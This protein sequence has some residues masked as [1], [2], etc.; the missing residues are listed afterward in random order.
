MLWKKQKPEDVNA[1]LASIA[2]YFVES[3]LTATGQHPIQILWQRSDAAATNQ[4]ALLGDALFQMGSV[5]HL[6]VSRRVEEIKTQNPNN[7]AGKVFELLGLNIFAGDGQTVRPTP[8]GTPGFDGTV[9]F[10]SGLSLKLSLKSHA[11]WHE[12][13]GP[14]SIIQCIQCVEGPGLQKW[15]LSIPDIARNINLRVLVGKPSNQPASK[16]I[17]VGSKLFNFEGH[18]IYQKGEIFKL[19]TV[20]PNDVTVGTLANP[21]A[22]IRV[23][24]V[25]KMGDGEMLLSG[26]FPPSDDL[27]LFS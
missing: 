15:W 2:T 11:S 1:R 25:M 21:V 8:D 14:R 19:V 16:A 23:H 26:M 3:W 22:G 5:D 12:A 4:L 27:V 6:W 10:A 24:A 20:N 9:T 17:R 18:Y 13:M 7:R